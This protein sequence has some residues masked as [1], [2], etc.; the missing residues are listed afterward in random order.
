[1]DQNAVPRRRP[2]ALWVIVVSFSSLVCLN[3]AVQL[4]LRFWSPH[5]HA[6]AARYADWSLLNFAENFYPSLLIVVGCIGLLMLRRWALY[7][8]GFLLLLRAWELVSVPF[9]GEFPESSGFLPLMVAARIIPPAIGFLYAWH[10]VRN[11]TLR[12]GVW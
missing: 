12:K 5:R 8:F 7:A 4:Y 3:V 2:L 10:L 11:G 1:M 9:P 6:L